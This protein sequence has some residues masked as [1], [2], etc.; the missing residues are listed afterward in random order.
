[1]GIKSRSGLSESLFGK[2]RFAVLR[3][4]FSNPSE[5]F[6]LQEVIRAAKTGQGAVEREVALLH[7]L[8]ILDRRVKGRLV[9]YQASFRCPIFEELQS[10]VLR[11]DSSAPG[12][13]DR[14]EA[15]PGELHR[16]PW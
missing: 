8:G 16:L 3:L 13:T 7:R 10:L 14:P 15:L 6:Y 9:L 11:I 5:P 12:H 2:T 1:M 4:F